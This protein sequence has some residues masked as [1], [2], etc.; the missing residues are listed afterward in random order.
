[1]QFAFN[2]QVGEQMQWFFDGE[3]IGPLLETQGFRTQSNAVTT[4]II[5]NFI[6]TKPDLNAKGINTSSIL[7]RISEKYVNISKT[8]D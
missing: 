5:S 2:Y 6:H 4:S 1:M 8:T 7:D 3:L